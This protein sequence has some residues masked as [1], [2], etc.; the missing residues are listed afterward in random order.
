MLTWSVGASTLGI[1]SRQLRRL[2]HRYAD[3]GLDGLADGRGR[4]RVRSS[5]DVSKRMKAL[6]G[7]ES[8]HHYPMRCCPWKAKGVYEEKQT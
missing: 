5:L 3:S 8:T 7:G 6:K 4:S 2:R 1:S